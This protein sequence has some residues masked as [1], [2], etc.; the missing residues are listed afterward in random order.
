MTND[1]AGSSL[2]SK[3]TEDP[4]AGAHVHYHV[5]HKEVSAMKHGVLV[6]EGECLIFQY[7]FRNAKVSTGIKVVIFPCQ[8]WAS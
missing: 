7:L 3:H 6:H 5:V 4:L 8:H 1:L 2:G